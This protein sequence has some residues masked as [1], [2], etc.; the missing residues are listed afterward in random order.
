[1]QP[2]VSTIFAQANGKSAEI[3]ALLIEAHDTDPSTFSSTAEVAEVLPDWQSSGAHEA[4]KEASTDVN[5]DTQIVSQL[6]AALSPLPDSGAVEVAESMDT[7]GQTPEDTTALESALLQNNPLFDEPGQTSTPM[8]DMASPAGKENSTPAAAAQAQATPCQL[9]EEAMRR[10]YE[11]GVCRR[12]VLLCHIPSHAA[13]GRK[14]GLWQGAA[15]FGLQELE[16]EWDNVKVCYSLSCTHTYMIKQQFYW[17]LGQAHSRVD[18]AEH[19]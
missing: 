10:A 15:E 19:V 14:S 12:C 11:K 6:G 4:T 8:D 18:P 5:E 17:L 1:M 13:T 16:K 2:R 3:V 7:T 9:T